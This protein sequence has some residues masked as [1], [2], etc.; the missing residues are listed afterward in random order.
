MLACGL[1]GGMLGGCGSSGS[2]SGSGSSENSEGTDTGEV[3]TIEFWYGDGNE[4]SNAIYEELISRFEEQNPQYKVNYVGLPNDSFLQKYNTAVATDTVPDIVYMRIS[5]ISTY[6]SQGA[7]VSLDEAFEGFEQKDNISAAVLDS[8]RA[9]SADG[10]LYALPQYVTNDIAWV[11]TA[12][13]GEK[14]IEVPE[15]QEEFL[16]LCEEYADPDNGKYFYSLRGGSGSA[17]NL[18]DFIFT[19]ANQ[20]S[21]FD[22]DGNCVLSDPIFAEALDTYASIYWNGWTSQDS[23]S[24]GFKEMVAEF[25][26]GTSMYINHNSS[27]LS[28]HQ[29]NLG[30]GNFKNVL[31]AANEEGYV[32]TKDPDACGVSIMEGAKNQEGAIA[33]MEFLVSDEA[34]S[35]L[36][37]QEGR[38]PVNDL[39]YDD[40]WYVNDEYNQV[41]QDML[42]NE[43]VKFLT[44]PAWLSTWSDF[45]SKYQEP[46]LQAVL[47]KER[48]SEEV[49]K[50]WADYLTEAQQ[51][52]L[53]SAQQ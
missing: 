30:E 12:L 39:V 53:A 43:N 32:V 7:L 13:M 42:E 8:I 6:I 34:V 49:L 24:N 23:V 18:F 27:S 16:A 31:A 51:E 26:S 17:E 47:L 28:E 45:K 38:I 11:N 29:K 25:G 5:D 19:Y 1:T 52:Y 35:Y 37:E 15:T 33:F 14:G 9:C 36:C 50:E 2:T 4:T 21:F 10:K 3:S 22:E 41:Y 46:G 20:D 40:E 48:T 44:H